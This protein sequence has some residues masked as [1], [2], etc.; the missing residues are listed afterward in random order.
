MIKHLKLRNTGIIF[1]LLV[2]Q[3]ASD[4]LKGRDSKALDI[5]KEFYSGENLISKEFKLYNFVLN[6]KNISEGK[7]ET[8]LSTITDIS[9]KFNNK[10]LKEEKYNLISKIKKYYNLDNFFSYKI[11]NYKPLAAL[12]KL[13]EAYRS[14]NVFD[15]QEL[16]QNRQ[17]LLEHLTSSTYSNQEVKDGLIEE[18]SKFDKDLRLLTYK[19]LLEKFNEKYKDILP[20]QKEIIRKFITA[21][22]S[23]VELRKI[24]NEELTSIC[25]ELKTKVDVI[26]DSVTKIKLE[27]LIENINLVPS[28]KKVDD[29]NL[30]DLLMYYE[31]LDELKKL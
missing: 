16:I 20:K 13:L 17:T 25:E 10:K 22:N 24:V 21:G 19:I 15:P 1:E 12:Y 4:T 18:Y 3:V 27:A 26:S 2:R 29:T 14:D 5:L 28:N 6:N 23:I 31:L 9:R 30:V 11:D 7:A 8:I